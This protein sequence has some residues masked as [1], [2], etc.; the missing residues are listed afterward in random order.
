MRLRVLSHVR[1]AGR[2][3][4]HPLSPVQSE[5]S[6]KLKSWVFTEEKRQQKQPLCFR[7]TEGPCFHPGRHTSSVCAVGG[8]AGVALVCPWP[9]PPAGPLLIPLPVNLSDMLASRAP[10]FPLVSYTSTRLW[11]LSRL[12]P[13][14]SQLI[15]GQHVQLLCYEFFCLITNSLLS[16][17]FNFMG[18]FGSFRPIWHQN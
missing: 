7:P 16:A 14:R 3:H 1:R 6:V 18:W 11:D 15:I 12:R 10:R 4:S 17:V 5:R 2:S 13:R 8:L 9:R